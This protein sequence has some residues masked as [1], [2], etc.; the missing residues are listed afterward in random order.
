MPRITPTDVSTVVRADFGHA[1]E[2]T[3]AA[4]VITF[5]STPVTVNGP[6]LEDPADAPIVNAP[7]VEVG[8]PDQ[9]GAPAV[10]PASVAAIEWI[11]IPGVTTKTVRVPA[12]VD[13][14]VI[15]STFVGHGF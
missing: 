13:Q 12:I 11:E 8:A 9:P 6:A 2:F 1:A 4:P 5:N 10:A 3:G 14:V 7:V 15:A